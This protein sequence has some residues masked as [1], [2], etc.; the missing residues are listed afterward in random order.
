MIASHIIVFISA[1]VGTATVLVYARVKWW[2]TQVGCYLMAH[3]VSIALSFDLL[4]FRILFLDDSSTFRLIRTAVLMT[5]PLS[6]I[7]LLK[8][9][10]SE[11]RSAHENSG[12]TARAPR[13]AP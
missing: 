1:L 5:I 9:L 10:I 13:K 4:A 8:L 6:M 2:K 11:Q 12:H 3:I 7:W